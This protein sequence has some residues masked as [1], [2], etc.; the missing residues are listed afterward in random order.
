M[1]RIIA[2]VT[3][4]VLTALTLFGCVNLTAEPKDSLSDNPSESADESTVSGP[5]SADEST[6][7][8]PD[9]A[10][11]NWSYELRVETTEDTYDSDDGVRLATVSFERPVLEPVCDGDASGAE[12]PEK[13]R[14]VC[15]KFNK[16][17][18]ELYRDTSAEQLG[19]GAKKQ[20]EATREENRQYFGGHTYDVSVKSSRIE[21]DLVEVT[22]G[23]YGFAGG[24]HGGSSRR[25]YHFD[26]QNGEFFKLAD[27]T[28]DYDGLALEIYNEIIRQI[29]ESGETDDYFPG[30]W[31]TISDRDD[32]AFSLGDDSLTVFFGEYEIAPYAKGI[33]EFEISYG[34]VCR[35]LNERGERLLAPSTEAK[36]VGWYYEAAEMWHWFDGLIPFDSYDRKAV[37][38]GDSESNYSRVDVPGINSI[39]DLRNK[40]LTRFS[41]EVAD[42]RLDPALNGT[43]YP[44]FVDIDGKL[45]TL[46]IG[47]GGNVMIRSVGYRAKLNEDGV[48]GKVIAT[49]KWQDWD[50][51]SGKWILTGETSDVEFPFELTEDGAIFTEFNSIW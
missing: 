43:D 4:L 31:E 11:V 41:E 33:C 17:F 3:A 8:D 38:T 44:L 30:F 26:L 7:S 37:R 18:D 22:I 45:Y 21:G 10:D 47:R 42:G 24:A 1:K 49:I 50:D 40:M 6:G 5:D 28:D 29:D 32:Y 12:A 27:I 14:A 25:G 16:E 19:E 46:P 36:A 48:S 34:E 51:E 23:I 20:Y 15:E 39:E 13:M 9:S 2:L 35:F